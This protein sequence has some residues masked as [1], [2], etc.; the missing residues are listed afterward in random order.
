MFLRVKD[1]NKELAYIGDSIKECQLFQ[2]FLNGLSVD[3]VDLVQ[4]YAIMG[5]LS[6]LEGLQGVLMAEESRRTHI[7][8]MMEKLSLN[9][10]DDKALFIKSKGKSKKNQFKGEDQEGSSSATRSSKPKKDKS[11]IKCYFCSKMGHYAS[12]CF[13][14]KQAQSQENLGQEEEESSHEDSL[15]MSSFSSS[16]MRGED[17]WWIDSE[18]SPHMTSKREYFSTL[19][20]YDGL[21]KSIFTANDCA[22]KVE[23]IG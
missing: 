5:K 11:K 10:G 9:D 15:M 20:T 19:S 14:R 6:S 13:K 21:I 7:K 1:L 18:A 22:C 2:L 3:F 17:P 16:S 23:D 4:G 12:E 8:S